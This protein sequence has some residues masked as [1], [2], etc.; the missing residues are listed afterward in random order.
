MIKF[1]KKQRLKKFTDSNFVSENM[2][3]CI[4]TVGLKFT[5]K[6]TPNDDLPTVSSIFKKVNNFW[7]IYYMQRSTGNSDLS[8]WDWQN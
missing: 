8:L 4:F 2:I 5:Y 7:K 6:R 1:K 3:I